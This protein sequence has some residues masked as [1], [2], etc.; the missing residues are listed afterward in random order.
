MQAACD[1]IIFLL[2]LSPEAAYV[3]LKKKAVP[4]S[5]LEFDKKACIIKA[6]I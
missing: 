4:L 1:F 2:I 6:Y 3:N 5:R